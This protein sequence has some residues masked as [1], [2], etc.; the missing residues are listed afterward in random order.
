MYVAEID[1]SGRIDQTDRDTVLAVANGIQYSVL[2]P[3]AEKVACLQMLRQR[4]SGRTPA[5]LYVLLFAT[6]LYFLIRE[7]ITKLDYVTIDVELETHE[8]R[9]KEHLLNLFRR[10][11]VTVDPGK[12]GF[13]HVGKKSPAHQLAWRVYNRKAEPS[14]V[15][16]A[17]D[18]LAEFRKKI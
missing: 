5:S 7:H 1:Q 10:R 9:I 17:D 4:W 6:L 15:L 18:V 12:I 16:T 3:K 11:G 14:R 13:G 8:S 2:F